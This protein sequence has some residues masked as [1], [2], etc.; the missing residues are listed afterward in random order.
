VVLLTAP[1]R[2]VTINEGMQMTSWYDIRNLD[3]IDDKAYSI[4]HILDSAE[5]I[6]LTIDKELVKLKSEK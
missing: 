1:I 3:R 2:S 5:I 6:N 4:E